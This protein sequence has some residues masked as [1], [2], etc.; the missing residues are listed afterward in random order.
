M[1][2]GVRNHHLK[3]NGGRVVDAT[4]GAVTITLTLASS[5]KEFGIKKIDVSANAVIVDGSGSETIDDSTTVTL[6]SQYD[7]IRIASDGTEW[8]VL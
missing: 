2:S 1:A 5:R 7:A 4:S 8:W 3:A 6:P